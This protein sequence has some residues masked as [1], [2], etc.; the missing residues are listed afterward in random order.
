MPLVHAESWIL[1]L[2]SMQNLSYMYFLRNF[3]WLWLTC[4]KANGNKGQSMVGRVGW[5]HGF[6]PYSIPDTYAS[7]YALLGTQGSAV[8]GNFLP[9]IVQNL[10]L[11][12]RRHLCCDL[13]I[14][15]S[16][17]LYL[18]DNFSVNCLGIHCQCVDSISYHILNSYFFLIYLLF[19]GLCHGTCVQVREQLSGA[20]S[21]PPP[22]GFPRSNAEPQ[23][24]Q[25]AFLFPELSRCANQFHF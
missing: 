13:K 5:T 17:L 16:C 25:W 19:R 1:V 14:H 8:F 20:D 2:S 18:S 23:A 15:I 12:M 4:K 3:K 10:A 22:C 9:W 7:K 24:W 11:Y 6:I 21:L